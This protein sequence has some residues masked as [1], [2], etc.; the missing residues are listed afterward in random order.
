M[1]TVSTRI[2]FNAELEGIWIHVNGALTNSEVAS[3]S[4]V[5]LPPVLTQ[6]GLRLSG[7]LPPNEAQGLC[8]VLIYITKGLEVGTGQQTQTDC[9][10]QTAK[11]KFSEQ[12]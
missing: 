5:A 3:F 11:E 10:I 9:G 1:L 8:S 7:R 12:K 4:I 6:I 2:D